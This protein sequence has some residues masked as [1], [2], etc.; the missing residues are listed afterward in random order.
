MMSFCSLV[1]YGTLIKTFHCYT[2]LLQRQIMWLM[3]YCFIMFSR[4]FNRGVT[5]LFFQ[6]ERN[7]MLLLLPRRGST[8]NELLT[9]M[10]NFSTPLVPTIMKK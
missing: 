1:S 5:L 9:N 3:R 7:S 8:L 6:S 10:A 4:K 2:Q